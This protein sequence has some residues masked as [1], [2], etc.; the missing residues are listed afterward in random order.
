MVSRH[1]WAE[2][3]KRKKLLNLV[4]AWTEL[5][6]PVNLVP[7]VINTLILWLRGRIFL[8]QAKTKTGVLQL[9]WERLLGE[10]E[11]SACQYTWEY[12]SSPF[13]VYGMFRPHCHLVYIGS[14]SVGLCSR[15]RSRSAKL[16]QL[17]QGKLVSCEVAVRFWEKPEHS[18]I[19]YHW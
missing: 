18:I 12:F 13:V 9:S 11:V 14:T 16:L 17:T 6:H 2:Y 10:Y 1:V 15:H 19:T 8:I 7:C 5:L 3:E 4:H